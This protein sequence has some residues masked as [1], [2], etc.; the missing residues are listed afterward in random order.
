MKQNNRLTGRRIGA[1]ATL[2]AVVTLGGA[3]MA[4]AAFAE[5][6]A[7]AATTH[8]EAVQPQTVNECFQWL[9]ANDY[10][11][12]AGRGWACFIGAHA[13]G[14]EHARVAACVG[15]MVATGVRLIVATPACAAASIPG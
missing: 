10:I 3:A 12:S 14:S 11:I 7:A 5:S 15:L 4:P 2:A 8:S 13:S 6:T 1:A 9:T